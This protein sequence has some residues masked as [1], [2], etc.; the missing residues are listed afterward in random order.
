MFHS[1]YLSFQ[2]TTINR[3]TFIGQDNYLPGATIFASTGDSC[4]LRFLGLGKN[5][6]NGN[7]A[8]WGPLA[9]LNEVPIK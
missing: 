5:R 3:S 1:E 2:I 7:H 8:S 6:T 9:L 4:L